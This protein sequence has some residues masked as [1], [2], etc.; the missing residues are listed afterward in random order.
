MFIWPR[1]SVDLTIQNERAI[2]LNLFEL[3]VNRLYIES[4][5]DGPTKSTVFLHAYESELRG[6]ELGSF[7]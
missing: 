7:G 3:P 6:L 4:V 2:V 5:L 1:N